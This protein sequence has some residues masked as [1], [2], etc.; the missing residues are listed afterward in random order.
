MAGHW[1]L[2]AGTRWLGVLNTHTP[3]MGN[4]PEGGLPPRVGEGPPGMAPRRERDPR[5]G[6]VDETWLARTRRVGT[7]QA[8][9][10]RGLWDFR[11]RTMG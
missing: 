1:G 10:L 3:L 2:A 7:G 8:R 4:P 6:R 11:H 9:P 5:W